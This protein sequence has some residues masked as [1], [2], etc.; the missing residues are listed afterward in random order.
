MTQWVAMLRGINVG[1]HH[2]LPM[3]E[4]RELVEGLGHTG[5]RTY[6]NSGNLVFTATGSV[7]KRTVELERSLHDRFG[8]AV[9][10]MIRTPAQLRTL[11]TK[12]PYP[13]GDPKQVTVAFVA[14]KIPAG[15]EARLNELATDQERFALHPAEVFIDF[16]G[17]LARSKLAASLDR[18]LGVGATTRNVRTIEKIL[19]LVDA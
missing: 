18:A 11:V 17:G 1:G 5:V 19:E 13:D 12:N 4:L 6:I 8:F 9:P 3:A 15:A 2:K 7:A 10:V 16:G 14:D